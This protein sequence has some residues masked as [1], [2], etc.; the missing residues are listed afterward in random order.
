MKSKTLFPIS[1]RSP[2]Q[3]GNAVRRL[4]K[5]KNL[6]Q[7]ELAQKAGLTQAT[8]SRI[9]KGNQKAEIHTLLLIFAALD[10]DLAI[11]ERTKVDQTDSLEGLY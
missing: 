3:I 11:T 4:R 7:T 8:V 10:A 1:V 9:E 6:S 2:A 5:I